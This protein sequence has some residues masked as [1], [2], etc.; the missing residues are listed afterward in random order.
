MSLGKNVVLEHVRSNHLLSRKKIVRRSYINK[1]VIKNYLFDK[2]F[3]FF[4][5]KLLFVEITKS[6]DIYDALKLQIDQK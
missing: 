2:S 3:K 4:T 6:N 5:N 1:K